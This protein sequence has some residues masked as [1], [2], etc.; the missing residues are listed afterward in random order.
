MVLMWLA[1]CQ[2]ATHD[3]LHDEVVSEPCDSDAYT[4]VKFPFR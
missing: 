3:A 1:E 4:E 2:S